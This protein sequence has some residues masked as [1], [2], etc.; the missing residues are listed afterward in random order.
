[1]PENKKISKEE[2]SKVGPLVKIVGGMALA[3]SVIAGLGMHSTGKQSLDKELMSAKCSVV[4]QV[5]DGNRVER[6]AVCGEKVAVITNSI[7]SQ[8][9][10]A[11]IKDGKLTVPEGKTA[12]LFLQEIAAGT[13]SANFESSNGVKAKVAIDNSQVE[14][15]TLPDFGER[16]AQQRKVREA[17]MAAKSAPS[18][19]KAISF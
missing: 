4:S 14:M 15:V 1:M 3:V 11:A 7:D 9:L 5:L 13:D 19:P 8:D 10:S 2:P 6:A 18:T 16:L 17:Q 12:R